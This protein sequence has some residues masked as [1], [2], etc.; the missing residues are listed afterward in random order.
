M[1][2]SSS[3]HIG[4]MSLRQVF[5]VQLP[6]LDILPNSHVCKYSFFRLHDLEITC[7]NYQYRK[8]NSGCPQVCWLV[9]L[10]CF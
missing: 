10:I 9:D 4:K 1:G 6:T 5:S 2:V 7:C 8:P 3:S